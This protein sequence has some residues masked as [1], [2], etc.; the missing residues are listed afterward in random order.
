MSEREYRPAGAEHL[1]DGTA[2]P[3]YLRVGINP[4][5]RD[6]SR[7]RRRDAVGESA[8]IEEE[9]FAWHV[10]NLGWDEQIMPKTKDTRVGLHLWRDIAVLWSGGAG[11]VFFV[12]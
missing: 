4:N 8:G 9:E 6:F 2:D 10:A 12:V 7:C 5:L 11:R 1:F 3:F